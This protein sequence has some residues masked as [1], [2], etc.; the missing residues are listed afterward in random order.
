MLLSK[1][2]VIS[3]CAVRTGCGKSGIT[4]YVMDI[5]RSAG[6]KAVAI[7]HPMPYCDLSGS[8][9][10]RFA[11]SE[12]LDLSSCTIEE[13]EE[14]EPL[15]SSGVV[16]SGI[17]L[18]GILH[19]AGGE[20]DII[21]WDG[22][23]NDFPFIKSDLEIV[24]FDP[25]RPGHE[26]TYHAGETNLRRAAIAV[27]NKVNTASPENIAAV[28]NNLRAV[29]PRATVI[30]VDSRILVDRPELIKGRRVLV[31]EDGPTLTHGGMAFGAGLLAAVEY[32]AG[33]VID[34]RPF[35]KGTINK[36]FTE[37]PHIGNVLPAVG[38]APAQMEELRSTI[39][40]ALC[41][42][43]IIATPVDLRKLL[44]LSKKVIR[45][46]YRIEETDGRLKG[47]IEDFIAGRIHKPDMP[48]SS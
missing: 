18:A 6:Y 2:P 46:G 38:Y 25:H 5:V 13:R 26:L 17:D 23:N 29:N 48:T 30:R 1:K 12:D 35:A 7:R 15:L 40:S 31:V 47:I 41:D 10:Q 36:V 39:E 22:G 32:G 8:R 43:V 44:G 37:Y 3:V 45:V 28:E 21:V 24:V 4:K 16:Y 14:L 9:F 33:E 19:K 34:P 11:R 20:A 27:I 42:L